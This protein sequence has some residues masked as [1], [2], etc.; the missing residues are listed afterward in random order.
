MKPG[1][2]LTRKTPLRAKVGLKSGGFVARSTPV[3]KRGPGNEI[4]SKSRAVVKRRS[5]GR[6]ELRVAADCGR[7]A[8]H[9]HHRLSRRFMNHEPVNLV[10]ICAPCHQF[11][12]DNPQL[13]YTS[14]WMLHEW[15]PVTELREVPMD[16]NC[17]YCEKPV[18][19]FERMR[20]RR[21]EGWEE[22][23]SGGGANKIMDR[24][25][26]EGVFAH[27]LCIDMHADGI[28]PGQGQI[29]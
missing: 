3:S 23:R 8:E 21:I 29:L 10:H 28:N 2:S 16:P 18:D 17:K 12:H 13:S 24:T 7:A 14:G 27:K 20:I 1:K 6:C 5:K 11:V 15:D 25:V 4:P 19:R 26:V 22:I 9:M